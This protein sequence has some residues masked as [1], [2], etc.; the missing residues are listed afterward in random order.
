MR[1]PKFAKMSSEAQSSVAMLWKLYTDFQNDYV[2]ERWHIGTEVG[3]GNFGKVYSVADRS[4]RNNFAVMKLACPLNGNEGSIQAATSALLE[5]GK[6]ISAL[7]MR[8]PSLNI[9]TVLDHGYHKGFPYFVMNKF[10]KSVSQLWK[11]ANYKLRPCTILRITYDVLKILEDLHSNGVA[12]GDI[13]AGNIVSGG[14]GQEKSTLFLIDFG[15]SSPLTPTNQRKDVK[16]ILKLMTRMLAHGKTCSLSKMPHRVARWVE[17]KYGMR[18]TER[19]C[20][21]RELAKL[22]NDFSESACPNYAR[23]LAL[24][25]NAIEIVDEKC[26]NGF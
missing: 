5:E 24:L 1:N 12:H 17:Y 23:M 14:A 20:F 8:A 10:G 7:N 22:V 6:I 25:T 11:E 21:A 16:S 13:H 26:E 4:G 18:S 9:P 2:A 15:K 3:S 19:Y